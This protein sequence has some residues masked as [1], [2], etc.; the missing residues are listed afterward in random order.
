M[1]SK[2]IQYAESHNLSLNVFVIFYVYVIF[3]L[4]VANILPVSAASYFISFL[5]GLIAFC[6]L[7]IRVKYK[8]TVRKNILEI[9]IKFF[10]RIVFQ[11]LD[12]KEVENIDELGIN[13][14]KSS[15]ETKKI[16]PGSIS[17]LIKVPKAVKMDMS[18]KKSY[19]ISTTNPDQ[20]I[21]L[22]KSINNHYN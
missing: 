21:N 8:I 13:D 6:I 17:Y 22:I 10:I 7:F 5:L 14:V 11:R 20:L 18:N 12:I 3:I 9:S 4:I 19:I 15:F 16:K 1:K 2:P